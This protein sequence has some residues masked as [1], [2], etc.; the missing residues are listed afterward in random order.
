[1]N[2]IRKEADVEIVPSNREAFGR[3]TIEAMFAGMP[4]IASDSGANPELVQH[5]R[6]GLLFQNGDKTDLAEKMSCFI[7][8][9]ESIEQMGKEAALFAMNSFTAKKNADAIEELY[10]DILK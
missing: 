4:V 1:M 7:E 3:V 8:N 10:Y 6:N 9:R 2:E 5:G